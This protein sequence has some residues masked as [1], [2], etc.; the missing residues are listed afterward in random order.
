MSTL[1]VVLFCAALVLFV[2]ATIFLA[3]RLK[4]LTDA[5]RYTGGYRKADL[6]KL[7]VRFMQLEAQAYHHTLHEAIQLVDQQ[8]L[9]NVRFGEITLQDIKDAEA[10]LKTRFLPPT[11]E[12]GLMGALDRLC[13]DKVAERAS[14]DMTADAEMQLYL[15]PEKLTYLYGLLALL[16]D[17]LICQGNASWC[18]ITLYKK[19][20]RILVEI[21]T[22][23]SL[24][25]DRH[26][27][28]TRE[29]F[30]SSEV[31]CLIYKNLLEAQW[32]W[33]RRKGNLRFVLQFARPAY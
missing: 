5:H 22:D 24:D 28:H 6:L 25:L 33:H 9:P 3:Y 20:R 14:L 12:E 13:K 21:A 27:D 2:A 17:D 1:Y 15:P 4:V 18:H 26:L 32:E 30:D 19:D 23:S 10:D 29:G 16:S 7:A 8:N 31:M 11:L